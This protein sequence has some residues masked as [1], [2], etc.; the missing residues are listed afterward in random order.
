MLARDWK[1]AASIAN[2]KVFA[3]EAENDHWAD[4]EVTREIEVHWLEPGEEVKIF[5]Y[6]GDERMISKKDDGWMRA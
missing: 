6:D 3:H 1:L 5:D 4:E 2:A